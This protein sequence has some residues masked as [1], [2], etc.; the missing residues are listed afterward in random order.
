MKNSLEGKPTLNQATSI[1]IYDYIK[2]FM[3]TVGP[4][5]LYSANDIIMLLRE[6]NEMQ[7]IN[8]FLEKVWGKIKIIQLKILI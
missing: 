4:K 1:T 3:N 8:A 6:N 2:L 7:L 5:M